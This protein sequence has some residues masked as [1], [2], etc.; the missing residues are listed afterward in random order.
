MDTARAWATLIVPAVNPTA[1]VLIAAWFQ[2][3]ANRAAHTGIQ[4]RIT[5]VDERAER[6]AQAQEERAERRADAQEE[7]MRAIARDL[8]FL[9]GRQAERDAQRAAPTGEHGA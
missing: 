8:A 4:D 2:H 6:H 9:A 3:R 7:V 5:R 1:A